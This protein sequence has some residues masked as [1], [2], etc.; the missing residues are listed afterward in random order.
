[1]ATTAFTVVMKEIEERRESI[2]QAL[3][4][5]SA[6]DYAGYRDMCGEIRGLSRTHVFITDL[7]RKMENDD[8]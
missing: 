2:A 1:M 6:K 4:S 5:G 3:I 8:D 7:V